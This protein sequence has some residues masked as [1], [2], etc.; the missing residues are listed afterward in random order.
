MVSVQGLD[1]PLTIAVWFGNNNIV[2]KTRA[3]GHGSDRVRIVPR[4]THLLCARG[5][6]G[7][8]GHARVGL[9]WAPVR[10]RLR[11]SRR[12]GDDSGATRNGRLA[13]TFAPR[14]SGRECA[15]DGGLALP[16]SARAA[17]VLVL[18]LVACAGLIGGVVLL[19]G[20]RGCA[21]IAGLAAGW[22]VLCAAGG[23]GPVSLESHL[24]LA[25]ACLEGFEFRGLRV[26]LLLPAWRR[27]E[28][29]IMFVRSTGGVAVGDRLAGLCV[30]VRQG[31]NREQCMC[32]VTDRL[33]TCSSRSATLLS[34]RKMSISSCENIWAI[35]L[36]SARCASVLWFSP[37][38]GSCGGRRL[39]E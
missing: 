33:S 31:G 12:A 21:R 24:H 10:L 7:V 23:V 13:F 27:D 26:D 5:E 17:A 16:R 20:R 6:R 34:M 29:A 9:G 2:S 4:E 37:R 32:R 36:Q 15:W 14:G 39:L 1:I 25:D 19:R 3:L 22:G 8:A 28:S 18:L 35:V 11:S 30:G 38:Q